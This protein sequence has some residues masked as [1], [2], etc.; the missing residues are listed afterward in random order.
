MFTLTAVDVSG[1][2]ACFFDGID[3][4]CLPSRSSHLDCVS[5]LHHGERVG[6][7]GLECATSHIDLNWCIEVERCFIA[8]LDEGDHT[9]SVNQIGVIGLLPASPLRCFLNGVHFLNIPN[10]F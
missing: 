4:V 7:N 8:P 1:A 2:G 9:I 10:R 5:S 6:H 3:K